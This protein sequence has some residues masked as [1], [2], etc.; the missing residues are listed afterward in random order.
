MDIFLCTND[1]YIYFLI[2]FIL[3]VVLWLLKNI[4]GSFFLIWSKKKDPWI[5]LYMRKT[6]WIA[7]YVIFVCYSEK[8]ARTA[9][10]N[11]Y[12]YAPHFA[13]PQV[14]RSFL[15]VLF[16]LRFFVELFGLS[17]AEKIK[18]L[19]RIHEVDY[20]RAAAMKMITK[21]RKMRSLCFSLYSS[22]F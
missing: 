2:S 10:K 11:G 16:S 21:A 15:I 6:V 20:D 19:N 22:S 3:T 5:F 4:H 18:I 14:I 13:T 1:I 8:G 17:T 7:D 9:C 12:S